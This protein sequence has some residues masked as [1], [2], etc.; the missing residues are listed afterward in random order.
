MSAPSP[1]HSAD[2]PPVI[3]RDAA[4]LIVVR[5]KR[6]VLMGMRGAGHKFMPNRLVFPGGRLDAADIGAQAASELAPEVLARMAVSASP[7]TARALAHAAARELT[8]ETGLSLGTPPELGHLDFLC[9]AVTPSTQPMRFDARFLVTD[10]EAV[11]GT[12]AGDGELEGL[13]WFE[14]EEALALEL[15]FVTR[16]VMGCLQEWLEMSP[17]ARRARTGTRRMYERTWTWE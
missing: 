1:T 2:R 9:S 16:K 4:S 6:L 10:A 8:E 3:P 17:E 15:A 12:L 5:D 7:E 13:R 14:I 11:T